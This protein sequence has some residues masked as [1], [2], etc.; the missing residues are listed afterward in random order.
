MR[1]P[2]IRRLSGLRLITESLPHN[3][4]IRYVTFSLLHLLL[5]LI[6]YFLY[7]HNKCRSKLIDCFRR[8]ILVV[9][10]P[11]APR[12]RCNGFVYLSENQPGTQRV[13]N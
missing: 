4:V 9:S 5:L 7:P 2:D 3:N 10:P 12:L 8:Q 1:I 6:I 13:L 11:A